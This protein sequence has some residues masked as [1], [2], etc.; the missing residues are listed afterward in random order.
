MIKRV[1]YETLQ[2]FEVDLPEGCDPETYHETQEFRDEAASL[3]QT[4]FI[5]FQ[6]ER[7]LDEN[8]NEIQ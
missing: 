8:R 2:F 7:K 6:L 5:E 1:V 4:G 3:I